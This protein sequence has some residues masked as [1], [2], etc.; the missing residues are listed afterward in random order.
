MKQWVTRKSGFTIVELLIVVVVIAILAAITIV[1]YNGIRERAIVSQVQT[2]LSQ[3]NKKVLA[4]A[5]VNADQFPATL[6]DAGVVGS[7]GIAYQYTTSAGAYAISASNGYPGTVQF[8]LSNSQTSFAKG[9]APGHNLAVWNEPAV[10]SQPVVGSG[11]TVTTNA[12]NYFSAPAA[13]QIAP[14]NI[15]RPIQNGPFVGEVGQTLT[16]TFRLKSTANWDGTS[17]HSKVRVSYASNGEYIK[18]CPY[19]GPKV[20]WVERTCTHVFTEANAPIAVTFGND[21]TVGEIWLDDVYV[22]IQ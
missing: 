1:A 2:A 11:V 16:L 4:Y 21:G 10:E 7:N 9:I 15:L 17:A 20:S 8:Y 22:S 5:A 14:N 13:I 6:N 19:N 12:S 3:A 18:Q